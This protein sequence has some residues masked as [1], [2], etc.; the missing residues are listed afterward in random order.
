MPSGVTGRQTVTETVNGAVQET[1]VVSY[2]YTLPMLVFV[3]FGVLA[4]LF[5]FLLKAEDKR[6]DYGLEK[7]IQAK[8]AEAAS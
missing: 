8:K 3:G 6:K 5:A 7:P 2:D 1:V 4:I